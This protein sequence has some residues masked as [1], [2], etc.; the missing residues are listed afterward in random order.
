MK[1]TLNSENAT[2]SPGI[3]GCIPN[4][5]DCASAFKLTD[6]IFAPVAK[7]FVEGNFAITNSNCVGDK[8][9]RLSGK[10]PAQVATSILLVVIYFPHMGY[11]SICRTS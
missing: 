11:H 3:C 2:L 4:L 9:E 8:Y 7:Y 5:V 6:G 1:L 10:S